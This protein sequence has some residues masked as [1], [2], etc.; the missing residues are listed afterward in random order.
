M[1]FNSP[2]A[3]YYFP[4]ECVIKPNYLKSFNYATSNIK[5]DI[6][7]IFNRYINSCY[8]LDTQFARLLEYLKKHGLMDSTI[9][10]IT[11]DHGEEF[12]EKGHWGHN[13]DFT[14]EQTRVPFILHI[15]GEKPRQVMTMSSHLD[16]VPTFLTLLGVTN[17]P[18]DYSQ[19]F[20]LLSKPK[21]QYT[22][23]SNWNCIGYIDNNYKARFSLKSF[24]MPKITTKNDAPVPDT[25]VFYQTHQTRLMEVIKGLSRFSKR[26]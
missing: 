6:K 10:L 9:V 7:L 2:H 17:P 4:K 13:S 18:D 14:E 3:R 15:P 21:R 16:V 1:F 25:K 22:I 11:G 24:N 5:R 8:H 23:V 19:G 26:K 12:M 20:D